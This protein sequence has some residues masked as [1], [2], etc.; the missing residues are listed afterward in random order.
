MRGAST[1][2][3]ASTCWAGGRSADVARLSWRPCWRT[4]RAGFE[5]ATAH[6]SHARWRIALL[7]AASLM[8][9]GSVAQAEGW[10]CEAEGHYHREGTRVE[11]FRVTGGRTRTVVPVYVVCRG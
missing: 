11:S 10:S 5:S 8:L 1:L 4:E 6:S 3:T 2:E 7:M 9:Q